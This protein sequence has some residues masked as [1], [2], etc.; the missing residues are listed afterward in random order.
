M[1]V[2]FLLLY[3]HSSVNS[4]Y[5]YV[6]RL[7][8]EQHEQQIAVSFIGRNECILQAAALSFF[9]KNSISNART[10][11]NRPFDYVTTIFL[12]RNEMLLMY[13][14]PADRK[15]DRPVCDLAPVQVGL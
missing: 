12:R 11:P 3:I 15:A 9:N 14:R 8:L 5:L 2:L 1:C 6:R 10:V 7:L 13:A 4:F